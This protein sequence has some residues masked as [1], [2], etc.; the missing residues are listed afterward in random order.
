LVLSDIVADQVEQ[1]G[2]MLFGKKQRVSEEWL[3]KVAFS[4][5]K[6]DNKPDHIELGTSKKPEWKVTAQAADNL[7]FGTSACNTQMMRYLSARRSICM[8]KLLTVYC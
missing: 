3:H 7:V 6:L 5:S 2:N 8:G 4:I 1:I